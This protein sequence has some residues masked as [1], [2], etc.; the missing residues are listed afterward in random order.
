M[1]EEFAVGSTASR[2]GDFSDE[3][4]MTVHVNDVTNL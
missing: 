4:P 1:C 3:K 2:I